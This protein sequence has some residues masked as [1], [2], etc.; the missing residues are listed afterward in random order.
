[1]PRNN[2]VTGG[3]S[4]DTSRK[5]GAASRKYPLGNNRTNVANMATGSGMINHPFFFP[6]AGEVFFGG[7]SPEHPPGLGFRTIRLWSN[8]IG[9]AWDPTSASLLVTYGT[10][11][12][13]P[14]RHC[15]AQPDAMLQR[16]SN[17]RSN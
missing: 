14:I 5:A 4:S 16:D 2:W 9:P 7:N 12:P 11:L 3:R 15:P 8:A 6:L 1:M 13:A 10:A 17:W